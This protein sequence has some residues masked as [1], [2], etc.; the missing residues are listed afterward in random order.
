MPKIQIDKSTQISQAECFGKIRTLL[1]SDPELK[2]L[3]PSYKCQF[4]EK[5]FG[6]TAKGKMFE[7]VLSMTSTGAKTNVSLV[8]SIP[9]MV[10]PFKGMIESVLKKKLDHILG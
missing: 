10:T 1:E 6:G 2:K 8:V 5:T 3:D 7:A 9:L 4:D